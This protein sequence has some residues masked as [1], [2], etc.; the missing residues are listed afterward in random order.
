MSDVEVV[1][2]GRVSKWKEK[3][4][5]ERWEEGE[6]REQKVLGA[7]TPTVALC[8]T[9]GHQLLRFSVLSIVLVGR[10]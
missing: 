8:A 9:W 6:R 3:E 2:L 4:K 7:Q 5:L 1:K 10:P